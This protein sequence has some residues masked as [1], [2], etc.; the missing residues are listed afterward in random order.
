NLLCQGMVLD[1][2]GDVMSKSKGNVIAPEDMIAE[3]GAD[4][5]RAYILFM[6]PPDKELLWN[7]DGLAGLFKF[8]NRVWR[9]V[10]DLVG[11]AG[12]DT[13]FEP[14]ASSEEVKAA[15]K[16]LNRERHRVVGKVIDDFDRN[17]FN[18]AIAAIMELSNAAG[19]FLR[20]APA[21]KRANCDFCGPICADVAEVL[22]KLMA[23]ICPHWAEEL[24]Q[25]VL[26]HED[27]VHVQA[28]PTFDPEQAKA[29]EVELAVQ[30]NGKVKAKITVAA[31]AAE[32]DIKACALEA[33]EAAVAGLD[34]KKVVYV[35]GR[36]VNIVA[37]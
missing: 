2:N 29:D 26:G 33:V 14:G 5:V 9:Q 3:Y 25:T 12:E 30:L 23:P 28:W 27:S 19:N 36:L 6:A 18:T 34:V 22:V 32:D 13:L 15:A 10:N 24:W 21:E 17:N 1:A 4:A 7:E 35:A 20:K 11:L 8:I 37:K 31:D 16:L